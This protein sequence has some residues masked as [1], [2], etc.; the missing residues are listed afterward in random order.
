MERVFIFFAK[1]LKTQKMKN[2]ANSFIT[3]RLYIFFY[4]LFH[5]Y[6]FINKL[7][8]YLHYLFYM[9]R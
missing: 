3:C 4:Y 6:L 1:D 5:Y 2:K 8:I 9:L 7:F